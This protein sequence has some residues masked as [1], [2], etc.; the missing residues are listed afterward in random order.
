[1]NLGMGR[2]LVAMPLTKISINGLKEKTYRI[3]RSAGGLLKKKMDVI[4]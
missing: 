2:S 3:D 4:I 1:M